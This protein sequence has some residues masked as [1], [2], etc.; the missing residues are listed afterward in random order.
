MRHAITHGVQGGATLVS[1]I[2]TL[3]ARMAEHQSPET[4][5]VVLLITLA[6]RRLR[7]HPLPILHRRCVATTRA[8]A[9]RAKG[10]MHSRS[11]GWEK[12]VLADTART[13]TRRGPSCCGQCRASCRW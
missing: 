5:Q 4:L 10:S 11:G 6:V 3:F 12:F 7:A 2:G 13:Q 1:A 8:S 9:S